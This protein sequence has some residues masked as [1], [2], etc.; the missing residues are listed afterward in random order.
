MSSSCFHKSIRKN[1]SRILSLCLP[2]PCRFW[3]LSLLTD[4]ICECL[5][6]LSLYSF[7]LC[8]T[9]LRYFPMLSLVGMETT[10]M[11]PPRI[12][13][14]KPSQKS[15]DRQAHRPNGDAQV[16]VYYITLKQEEEVGSATTLRMG[17]SAKDHTTWIP[18][19]EMFACT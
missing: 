19:Y 7:S 13:Q 11:W 3:S 14:A 10:L 17:T 16:K 18:S 9:T 2:F 8:S 5:S 4:T 6:S 1:K 12:L 15:W